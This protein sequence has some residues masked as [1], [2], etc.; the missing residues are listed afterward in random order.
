MYKK[1]L[2][3]F[4]LFIFIALIML[5]PFTA[6]LLDKQFSFIEVNSSP[7]TP[8]FLKEEKAKV[9][10][11]YF[12]YVGCST[13]CDPRLEELTKLYKEFDKMGVEVPLYFVNLKASQEEK[14]VKNYASSFHKNFHG[15][16]ANE[17]QIDQLN[18]SFNLSLSKGVSELSHT[19]NLFLMLKE[20]KK[21]VLKYIFTTRPYNPDKLFKVIQ[22]YYKN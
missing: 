12:G 11:L 3:G 8:W 5:F 19:S 4:I 17:N 10:L 21:Y 15:V 9:V 1:I 16:Y 18:E 13:I 20:D 6:S 22:D 14:W 2:G 7:K